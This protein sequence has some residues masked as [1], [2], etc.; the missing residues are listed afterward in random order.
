MFKAQFKNKSPF[1]SWSTL[2]TYGNE[3]SAIS[4]A[5]A[6]KNRGALLVRVID[7]Q[8]RVIYSG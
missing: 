4:S 3:E 8:G 2:G 6:K 5:L 1:E 7:K